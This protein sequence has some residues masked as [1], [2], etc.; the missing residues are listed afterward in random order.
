MMAKKVSSDVYIGPFCDEASITE[1][2]IID[3][4]LPKLSN[5]PTNG[6]VFELSSYQKD[7]KV[8]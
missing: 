6:I 4:C 5:G 2:A 3:S 7:H 8:C 1:L